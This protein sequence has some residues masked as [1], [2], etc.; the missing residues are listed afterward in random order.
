MSSYMAADYEHC[1]IKHSSLDLNYAVEMILN[2][3][4]TNNGQCIT[5]KMTKLV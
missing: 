5:V 3:A 4:Y 2:E 1:K